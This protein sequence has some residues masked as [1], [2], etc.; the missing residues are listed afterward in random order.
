[1][2]KRESQSQHDQIVRDVYDYLISKGCKNVKADLKG[3]LQPDLIYWESTGKGHIPDMTA[4]WNGTGA[5]FEAETGDSVFDQHTEDQWRLFA[6][7]AAQYGKT[8]MVVIPKGSEAS[9]KSRLAQ[10]G[11]QAEVWT[12]A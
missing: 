7:N 12:V 8:F 11:I 6:A 4:S 2:A 3:L 9:A 1:M 10:L 5:I